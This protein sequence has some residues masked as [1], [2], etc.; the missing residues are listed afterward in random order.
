G[1]GMSISHTIVTET[2]GGSLRLVSSSGKGAS[3]LI[4]LPI[5][6]QSHQRLNPPTPQRPN[7]PE[8]IGEMQ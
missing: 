2:H 6:Q 1:L 3:F 8:Q 5:T 7:S 4:E